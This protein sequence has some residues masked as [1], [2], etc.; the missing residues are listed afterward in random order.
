MKF[1]VDTGMDKRT[2]LSGIAKHFSPE[3]M[4][5]KQ[6]TILANLA[7]RKIMGTESQGMILMAENEDG[8]L[9]LIQP[10]DLTDNGAM[11]S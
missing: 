3:E 8:S 7:P 9:K 5:G 1:L 6:V 2:I 11:V 10:N 4:I